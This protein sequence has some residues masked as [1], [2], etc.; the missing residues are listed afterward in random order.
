[1]DIQ[2]FLAEDKIKLR[3][4]SECITTQDLS[5]QDRDKI[6]VDAISSILDDWQ[7]DPGLR[8]CSIE[9]IREFEDYLQVAL[10]AFMESAQVE[11]QKIIIT[12]HQQ[13]KV[14]M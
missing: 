2:K 10:D 13:T 11:R 4:E 5:P 12:N 1:M 8:L 3:Q 14:I 6:V 7:H 9:F